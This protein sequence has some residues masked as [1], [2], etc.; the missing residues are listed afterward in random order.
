MQGIDLL[1]DD[2]RNETE[3]Y[4]AAGHESMMTVSF[5]RV[6]QIDMYF[7][8]NGI[9]KYCNGIDRIETGFL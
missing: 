8:G 5:G 3:A 9:L 1:P 2:C 4:P 7:F 6:C